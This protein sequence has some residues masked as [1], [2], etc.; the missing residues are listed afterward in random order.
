VKV[1]EAPDLEQQADQQCLDE[2]DVALALGGLVPEQPFA[3]AQPAVKT[4]KRLARAFPG[5]RGADDDRDLDAAAPPQCERHVQER[6][7]PF[8]LIGNAMALEQP[9]RQFHHRADARGYDHVARRIE[10]L[11]A[12]GLG[13]AGHDG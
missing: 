9:T 4:V 8:L 10:I 13:V 1:R 2:S 6:R 5:L 12:E 3:R 11:R 7:V